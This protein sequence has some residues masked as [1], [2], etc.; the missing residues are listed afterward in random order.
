M[1]CFSHASA[2]YMNNIMKNVDEFMEQTPTGNPTENLCCHVLASHDLN[3]SCQSACLIKIRCMIKSFTALRPGQNH[4]HFS[5]NIY[6]CRAHSRFAPN[7]FEVVLLCNNISHWLGA[8]IESAL[9]CIS[10]K[11]KISMFWLEFHWNLLQRVQLII[12]QYWFR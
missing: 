2:F 11:D 9:K 8:S 4:H 5:E 3:M 1:F 10:L 6:K 7:Q 12:S